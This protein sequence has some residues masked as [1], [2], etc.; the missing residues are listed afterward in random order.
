MLLL[1]LAII[2]AC[3]KI[4]DMNVN[5][6]DPTKTDPNYQFNYVLQ[7]GMGNYNSDVNLEQWGLMNWVMFMA[8]RGGVEPGKEYVIPSGK[9]DY[10]REQ[11]SNAISNTQVII[12]M[13]EENSELIN[14]KAAAII[15]KINLANRLTDLWGHIPYS[16][17]SKGITELNYSP[18]YDEQKELYYQMLSELDEAVKMFN[19]DKGFF[20]PE[21][22]LIYEGDI[23][24]WKS[25]GNSLRLR[26]ATRINKVDSQKY[27]EVTNELKSESLISSNESSAL[28][29]FNSV[30]KNHLYEVM[31]RGEAIVQNNPSK[32][33]VDLL[34]NT[35]DPRTPVF[36]EKAPLS[37]LPIYDD[38]KGVPNLVPANDP[39]WNSYNPDGDW[40]DISRIGNWFL[41]NE[42][43]GVIMSYSEVCFLKAEAALNGIW[44][45]SPA[46]FLKE[47]IEANMLF[48]N[49]HGDGSNT[50]AAEEINTYISNL[51]ATDL[52]QIITQKWITFIFE[53]G[54]EAYSEYRRTGF[55]VLTDYNGEPIDQ[56]IFPVRMIYPYSEYTLNRDDYNVAISS[57][58][59]DNEFTHIWWDVE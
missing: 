45:G 16:D 56:S 55:P 11:Y 39:I 48:Y 57:Q 19:M 53:K 40:G 46:D 26:L 22:D 42:T 36:L 1:A 32:F 24:K 52:E 54:Y 41:R 50:I 4:T 38:Y 58:G 20:R 28:F 37:F 12:D 33:M 5:P 47:A 6:N 21:A 17:A 9:D 2:P 44:D 8:A 3:T 29:P 15:W 23:D 10:W 43:P 13:A 18:A 31:F 35:N 59:A 7:Q 14:M 27:Q 30:V 34:V 25:F 49:N 51:P